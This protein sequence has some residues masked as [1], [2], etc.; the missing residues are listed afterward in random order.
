MR[1]INIEI[2]E[3]A[4]KK[5]LEKLKAD[6]ILEVSFQNDLYRIIPT[7]EWEVYKENNAIVEIGS[8]YDDVECVEKLAFNNERPCTYVD[9]DR[10]A[11]V[12]RMISEVQNS[13][14]S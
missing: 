10:V 6:N 14:S 4:F 12:L 8:L 13:P 9:F 11:S 1:K 5:I 3:I 2:L 7:D